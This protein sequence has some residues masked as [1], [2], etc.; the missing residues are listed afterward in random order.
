MRTARVALLFALLSTTAMFMACDKNTS[1]DSSKGS[2]EKEE[3]AS[4]HPIWGDLDLAKR[5]DALQGTW[6]LK[7]PA[8]G[9]VN[10]E[11]ARAMMEEMTLQVEGDSATFT[12]AQG[13]VVKG[14]LRVTSPCSLEFAKDGEEGQL[15]FDFAASGADVYLGL[16]GV[17]TKLGEGFIT[18][19]NNAFV[20]YDGKACKVYEAK[21]GPKEGFE[22][23]IEVNCSFAG[24]TFRYQVPSFMD[25][26][27]LN[28]ETLVRSGEV[29]LSEQLRDDHKLTKK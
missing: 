22:P 27:K 29:L 4:K 17:G 6:T 14:K 10:Y 26:T 5:L 7:L 2:T 20:V 1:S 28:E 21:F 18:C 11:G 8:M 12:A 9:L 3:A 15:R 24:D 25:K 19:E 13:E 16:G 23:A